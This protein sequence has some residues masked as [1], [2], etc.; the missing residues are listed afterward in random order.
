[1]SLAN[2]VTEYEVRKVVVPFV[3]KHKMQLIS[4]LDWSP[5]WSSIFGEIAEPYSLRLYFG[6]CT[7]I[8]LTESKGGVFVPSLIFSQSPILFVKI[9]SIDWFRMSSEQIMFPCSPRDILKEAKN[10]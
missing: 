10:A 6:Y 9:S 3:K 2:S 4:S 7:L 8:Y 5:T 1:M